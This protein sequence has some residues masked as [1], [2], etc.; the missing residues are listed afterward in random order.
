MPQQL[1][2]GD[3]VQHKKNGTRG[4]VARVCAKKFELDSAGRCSWL[5]VNFRKL[6]CECFDP[7]FTGNVGVDEF[8]QDPG[9][10]VVVELRMNTGVTKRACFELEDFEKV[11]ND[12]WYRCKHQ[13][14]TKNWELREWNKD[15]CQIY[16]SEMGVFIDRRVFTRIIER[17]IK[18]FLKT[19]NEVIYA[20][21]VLTEDQER[22]FFLHS[23]YVNPDGIANTREPT[24]GS[25][26]CFS[27]KL[28]VQPD[29]VSIALFADKQ[30][31]LASLCP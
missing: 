24:M 2:I 17:E 27:P 9:N 20:K 11:G 13:N 29:V 6:A 15:Y 26:L 23:A 4:R 22:G 7:I 18:G 3:I 12:I 31:L 5:K 8:V 19:N 14:T 1:Q 10:K 28:V 30:A 25:D 16:I 21:I